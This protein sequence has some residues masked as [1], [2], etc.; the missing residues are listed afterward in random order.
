MLVRSPAQPSPWE[1]AKALHVT[2]EPPIQGETFLGPMSAR[3]AYSLKPNHQG[4]RSISLFY[5]V[6]QSGIRERSEMLDIQLDPAVCIDPNRFPAS[7]KFRHRNNPGIPGGYV[8]TR[9]LID[10]IA[11]RGNVR[12]SF[13]LTT[14]ENEHCANKATFFAGYGKDLY[15]KDGSLD[16][17]E[18]PLMDATSIGRETLP[19][20]P[21]PPLCH[22]H[23]LE[24]ASSPGAIRTRLYHR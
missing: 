1:V 8:N 23:L 20:C 14:P 2:L 13:I 15:R 12:S 19:P 22:G 21:L 4:I 18:G 16:A 10:Y 3:F 24:H 6:D 11:A 9:N 7:V 5:T 17:P